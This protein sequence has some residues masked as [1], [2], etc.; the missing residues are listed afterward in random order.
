MRDEP[1]RSGRS[2]TPAFSAALFLLAAF[3]LPV[4]AIAA[5]PGGETTPAA[6]ASTGTWDTIREGS[7]RIWDKTK[8]VSAQSW[9][10]TRA[11][12]VRAWD[13]TREVSAAVWDATRTGSTRAW[14]KAME[15]THPDGEQAAGE[16]PEADP[17]SL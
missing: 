12:S 8:T 17:Q 16:A 1:M 7:A 14:Q 13:K 6:D 15:M 2:G 5:E 10:A 11:G 9:D 4:Q 3:L